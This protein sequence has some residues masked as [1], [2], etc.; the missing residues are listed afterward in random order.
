[1]SPRLFASA[2]FGDLSR[3]LLQSLLLLSLLAI[4]VSAIGLFVRP[5][6]WQTAGASPAPHGVGQKIR[7]IRLIGFAASIIRRQLLTDAA[8]G[9]STSGNCDKASHI[10]LRF[11]NHMHWLP[12]D[13]YFLKWKKRGEMGNMATAKKLNK[14]RP[15]AFIS[16]R[17]VL[18]PLTY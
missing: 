9:N 16:R 3:V 8:T 18:L 13:L 15:S 4:S 1:M 6:R 17:D 12:A 14:I 10:P 5:G 7:R 11:T 2:A